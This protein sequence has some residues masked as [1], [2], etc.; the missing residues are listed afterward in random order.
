PTGRQRYLGGL[1]AF[2]DPALQDAALEYALQG[3]VRVNE[4][5]NITGGIRVQSDQGR[6]RAFKWLRD[7]YAEVASKIPEEFQASLPNYARGC[8][9]Q[10]I[11]IAKAFFSEPAHKVQGTEKELAQVVEAVDDCVG[12]RGREGPAVGAYLRG[13]AASGTS[14]AGAP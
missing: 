13:L 10:R 1:G 8:D 12:L 7:H 3:P 2:R 4:I 5:R 14:R 11:A 9:A 6:D